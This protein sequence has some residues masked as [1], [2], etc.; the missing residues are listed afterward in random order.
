[1]YPW[2]PARDLDEKIA[3]P[4]LLAEIGRAVMAALAAFS[5][6]FWLWLLS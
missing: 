3:P 4:S 5:I 2:D 6:C 1:M